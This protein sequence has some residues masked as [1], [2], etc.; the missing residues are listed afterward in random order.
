MQVDSR[1]APF[2]IETDFCSVLFFSQVF[3]CWQFIESFCYEMLTPGERLLFDLL[4]LNTE[5]NESPLLP[6]L[7]H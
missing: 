2:S 6:L 3:E 1:P 7:G 5:M 4:I